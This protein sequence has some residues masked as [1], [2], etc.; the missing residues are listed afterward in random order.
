MACALPPRPSHCNPIRPRIY[1]YRGPIP[2]WRNESNWRFRNLRPLL[3]ESIYHE[4]D[5]NC[6]DFFIVSNHA[7][8]G[9]ATASYGVLRQDNAKV[10]AMFAHIRSAWPWW[11]RTAGVRRHFVLTPCDHGPGDCMY[12]SRRHLPAE[13][14]PDNPRRSIGFLTPTGAS[15]PTAWFL[16]DVDIRLPQ[17]EFGPCSTFCGIP[18]RKR[19]GMSVLREH[20]PWAKRDKRRDRMLRRRRRI[21]FFW[22]GFSGG[23]KGFRG[24]LFRHHFNRSRWLIRDTS[25]DGRRKGR[26]SA[27]DI[28]EHLGLTGAHEDPSWFARSMAN[29]DFCYSPLGQHHGDSDRSLPA[30]LYGCIPVFIKENE[31][32]PFRELLP[33]RDFSL[34]LTPAHIPHLDAHLQNVSQERIVSMREAMS[35]WWPR[36]LWPPPVDAPDYK[37]RISGTMAL[38]TDEDGQ[39]TSFSKANAFTTW[40][41]VLRKRL[42]R[43][44]AACP[45]R[46]CQDDAS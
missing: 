6:A 43:E 1:W 4:P 5:G 13:I 19:N 29:S 23:T 34:L 8:Y 42:A 3:E 11:N 14:A 22:S 20:S 44:A 30:L 39:P 46:S 10:V 25:P 38:A 40:I 17:E 7:D 33:W 37:P 35:R 36:L 28:P 12:S 15:G 32:G 9:S 45:T 18:S 2:P 26:A 24:S 41:E 16:P 31:E 27:V 21:Q